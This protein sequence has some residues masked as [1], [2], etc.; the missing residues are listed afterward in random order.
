MEKDEVIEERAMNA[1]D[2]ALARG[3][4]QGLEQG[5][6]QGRAQEKISIALKLMA[7]GVPEV[8]ILQVTGLTAEALNALT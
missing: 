4:K 7:N 6:D 8:I 3:K 1:I 5:L 2:S